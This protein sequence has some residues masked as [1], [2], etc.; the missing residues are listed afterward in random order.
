MAGPTSR[1][2]AASVV[3]CPHDPAD[4]GRPTAES[5]LAQSAGGFGHVG[6]VRARHSSAT[7]ERM[8]S[9]GGRGLS[10]VCRKAHAGDVRE[11]AADLAE[12]VRRYV[13][14][15]ESADVAAAEREL[16]AVTARA[17]CG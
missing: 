12:D 14:E 17:V 16:V 7:P 15:A 6:S 9:V 4:H 1:R 2:P 11:A 8:K 10:S 3:G 13:A 5:E